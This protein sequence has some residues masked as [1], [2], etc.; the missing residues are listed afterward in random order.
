MNRGFCST[1]RRGHQRSALSSGK[2]AGAS[3]LGQVLR[4][5]RNAR[6]ERREAIPPTACFEK[7]ARDIRGV[8]DDSRT[9]VR[10]KK[11]MLRTLIEEIVADADEESS[12]LVLLVH[13]KRGVHTE[14]PVPGQRR[15]NVPTDVVEAVRVLARICSDDRI[16]AWLTRNGLQ[17]S[18]GNC[19]TRQHELLECV[20]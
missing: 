19:W 3:S 11:R 20:S 1:A 16:A 2:F 7:L 8:R 10:L 5:F 9:N 17:T 14:L 18:A 13:W 6:Q 12:E 4:L 15:I